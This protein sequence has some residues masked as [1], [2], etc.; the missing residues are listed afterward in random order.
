[1]SK[2][3][4]VRIKGH[5]DSKNDRKNILPILKQND[6]QA[7]IT[8]NSRQTQHLIT[9]NPITPTAFVS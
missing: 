3:R 7:K 6:K 2:T 4:Q 9:T 1:M 8:R 5:L